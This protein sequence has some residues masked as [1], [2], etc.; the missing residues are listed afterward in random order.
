MIVFH[1]A[2]L[3]E[4]LYAP[5]ANNSKKGGCL[6]HTRVSIIKEITDWI[7]EPNSDG[8]A[9]IFWLYGVA[10]SGKSAI[11]RTIGEQ[12]DGID[13]LGCFF[14]FVKEES[15]ARPVNRLFS[16]I[17]RNIADLV[18]EWRQ[19]LSATLKKGSKAMRTT[20]SISAQFNRFILQP[21]RKINATRRIVVVIDAL[22]EAGDASS[23]R[24]LLSLLKRFG[25]LPACFRI[26]VTSRPERD[27]QAVLGIQPF[28]QSKDMSS[29][30]PTATHNDIRSFI[31][32]Q[33]PKMNWYQIEE[34]TQ[35]AEGL[36]EWAAIACRS[37]R[38]D[39][40]LGTKFATLTLPERLEI[41]LSPE[42]PGLDGLYMTILRQAF[43][44]DE[45]DEESIGHQR[46]QFILAR[47]LAV[48]QPVTLKALKALKRPESTRSDESDA[49]DQILSPL[50]AL[51]RG[52]SPNAHDPV[53]P[54]HTSFRD[55]LMTRN[56]S[57]SFFVDINLGHE[58]LALA[59]IDIMQRSLVFNICHLET[60]YLQ[61]SNIT[62]LKERVSNCIPDALSYACQYWGSH[63][64]LCTTTKPMME[65]IERFLHTKAFFWIE[66]LSLIG[67]VAMA[68]AQLQAIQPWMEVSFQ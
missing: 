51:L 47:V 1:A 9:R 56:R 4:M 50:G 20:S 31:R 38:E 25:E 16:T 22:D 28:V 48:F 7:H 37:L 44:F 15:L 33:L 64:H 17:S 34:L 5:E 2:N 45:A 19:A 52:L 6:P 12:F 26:L 54:L 36:F 13:R 58:Q 59:T 43:G 61:N 11:A 62:G 60:S 3:D 23:R 49:V 67:K 39:G 55:F 18:P 53:Q 32:E 57:K 30:K 29:I 35:K 40:V 63:A 21:A 66:A 46:Y 27:I 10:G 65:R 41:I 42:A 68:S 14:F 8:V 24:D